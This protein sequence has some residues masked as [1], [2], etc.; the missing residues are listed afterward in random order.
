MYLYHK[1]VNQSQIAKVLKCSNQA[2]SKR[3]KSWRTTTPHHSKNVGGRPTKIP[4]KQE[5]AVEKILK[6]KSRIGTK[7]L[8]GVVR[9]KTG[10]VLSARTLRRFAHKKGFIW[11]KPRAV[12]RLS[13]IQKKKRLAFAKMYRKV[14][15][16]P[17]IFTDEKTFTLGG[18][19]AQ[20]RY[21]RGDRPVVSKWA[22]PKKVHVWWGVSLHYK[23]E[24]YLFEQNMTS[25]LYRSILSARLPSREEN[26]WVL[27]QDNDPKHKAKQTKI[28][29]ENNT[30]DFIDD[31]PSNSADLNVIENLWAVLERMVNEKEIRTVATLKKRIKKAAAEINDELVNSTILSFHHRLDA[32]IKAKGGAT[33]Y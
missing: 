1:G 33:L 19:K 32:V 15:L 13:D 23:I 5:L 14:D 26:D 22:H 6:T 30:P 31:W 16:T 27:Q 3:L 24:P 2:V 9:D 20:L 18:M 21:K 12:P 28:W 11:G 29:L 25:A 7:H 4:R 10:I 17:W 8:V